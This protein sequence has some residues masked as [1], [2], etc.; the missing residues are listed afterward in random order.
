MP[1]ETRINANEICVAYRVGYGLFPVAR[2]DF[3]EGVVYDYKGKGHRLG[4]L[5]RIM[6]N[7]RIGVD[8]QVERT[9]QL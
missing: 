8:I 4:A 7:N 5:C 1:E 6:I 3:D 2:I 9:R